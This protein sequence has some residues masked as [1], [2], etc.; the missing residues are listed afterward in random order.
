M[1]IAAATRANAVGERAAY[2]R[3][4]VPTIEA[5]ATMVSQRSL[6]AFRKANYSPAET[7]FLYHVPGCGIA[8]IT[9]DGE[10]YLR[11]DPDGQVALD[12]A[13][14]QAAG[15]HFALHG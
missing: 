4:A 11:N 13:V 6:L 2:A 1:K 5:V 14:V 15:K 8:T 3:P 7:F 9:L 12:T 10:W